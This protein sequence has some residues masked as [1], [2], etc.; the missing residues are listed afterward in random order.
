[1]HNEQELDAPIPGQSLTGE[2]RSKPWEQPPQLNTVD[3]ALSHYLP[4][5]QD[6]ELTIDLMNH[7]EAG[8]SLTTMA[9][10]ITKGGVMS[11]LHSIDVGLQVAPVLVE[12]MI[13]TADAAGI[14][15]KIGTE[16][17]E[18]DM[19]RESSIMLAMG[20]ESEP[21]PTVLDEEEL[22]VEAP[23]EASSGLMARRVS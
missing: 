1:M 15:Y 4:R 20:S 2:P 13:N 14:D 10:L 3:E 6:E 23:V 8:V 9:D 11:G 5:F 17:I 18:S 21:L 19:P 7:I 12:M 22:P 16:D